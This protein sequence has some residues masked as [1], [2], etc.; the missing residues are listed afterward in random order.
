MHILMIGHGF[1]PTQGGV[2]THIADLSHELHNRGDQVT[3]LVGAAEGADDSDEVHD[4]I[5]VRR[6]AALRPETL[7]RAHTGDPASGDDLVR[8]IAKDIA[9]IVDDTDL[10]HCHNLHHFGDHAARA[11]FKSAGGRPALNTVHDHAG[12]HVLHDVLDDL[13]WTRLV[14]VSRFIRERLPSPLPA[15]VLHLGIDLRRFRPDGPAYAPFGGLE[16]PVV[17]HP[18]RLLAWKGVETGLDAFVRVR[19]AL[20]GG[21]LVLTA[22][23]DIA[24]EQ[25]PTLRLRDRLTAQA[26]TAGVAGHVRFEDVPYDGMPA[27]L[28]ASDLVWYPTTG[29]EPY[30]LVPLEAMA[31]E[32]PVVTSDSGGMAETMRHGRTGLVVPRSDPAALAGAAV[33]VLGDRALRERLVAGARAHVRG[34]D[35]RAYATRLRDLYTACVSIAR[36]DDEPAWEP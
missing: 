5:A 19:A 23:A 29:E 8:M 4:G 22:G 24:E 2:E 7:R 11:V 33:S 27:A 34:F 12:N 30:G 15:T 20:G 17:F 18:A 21:T 10:I 31:C 16:R 6:R 1:P 32:V 35:L 28:R 13:P 9:E 36:A 26:H 3:C 14:Y 25:A